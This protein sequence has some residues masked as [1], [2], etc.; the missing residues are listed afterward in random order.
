M[1]KV[2]GALLMLLACCPTLLSGQMGSTYLSTR[3]R[4]SPTGQ[5]AFH[6]V[7]STDGS[8]LYMTVRGHPANIGLANQDDIW[9][10]YL[11]DSSRWARPIHAGLPLNDERNN[12][13]MALG[14]DGNTIYVWIRDKDEAPTLG[15]AERQGRSWQQPEAMYIEGWDTLATAIQHWQVNRQEDVLL[16]AASLPGTE[17]NT[18]LFVSIRKNAAHWGQPQ[19]LEGYPNSSFQETSAYLAPDN[20]TLYFSSNRPGG[21]GGQDLYVCQRLDDSWSHWSSPVNLGA[22][23]NSELDEVGAC[24][25]ETGETLYF[26]VGDNSESSV[27]E[28]VLRPELQPERMLLCTGRVRYALSGEPVPAGLCLSVAEHGTARTQYCGIQ[29]DASGRFSLLVPQMQDVLVFAQKSSFFSTAQLLSAPGNPSDQKDQE[30]DFLGEIARREPTYRQREE[31]IQAVQSRLYSLSRSIAEMEALRRAALL[32]IAAL[33]DSFAGRT[34]ITWPKD[35]IP[36]HLRSS[37]DATREQYYQ[38]WSIP[39]PV[40]RGDVDP[41]DSFYLAEV[42]REKPFAQTAEGRIKE[43]HE[44]RKWK[45]EQEKQNPGA[46][47]P[48]SASLLNV[49]P[50][51]FEDFVADM[52]GYIAH[53]IQDSLINALEK[54]VFPQTIIA[55]RGSFA[56]TELADFQEV[57]QQIVREKQSAGRSG[58]SGTPDHLVYTPLRQP[59][60]EPFADTLQRCLAQ[61]VE[62]ALRTRLVNPVRAFLEYDILQRIYQKRME[63]QQSFLD[64]LI[65][66]QIQVEKNY[67]KRSLPLNPLSTT[68]EDTLV[69]RGNQHTQFDLWLYPAGKSLRFPLGN[70]SFQSNEAEMSEASLAELHR[71]AAF[72]LENPDVQ[73]QIDLYIQGP[74]SYVFAQE[75]TRDRAACIEGFLVYQEGVP[76]D[77]ISVRGRGK[78]APPSPDTE[79]QAGSQRIEV[80]LTHRKQ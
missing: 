16:L 75:L 11:S 24:T 14:L 79:T 57:I 5:T 67:R 27:Y 48:T 1:S 7:V 37:Y 58:L 44:R 50:S 28:A 63:A 68:R 41:G 10:A 80:T 23:I 43:L 62:S 71:L 31:D 56:E 33:P 49:T 47:P 53:T 34:A 46:I 8:A 52:Q 59:W 13:A 12:Q 51:S 61:S 6:P 19:R 30:V 4:I 25:S 17:G 73:A 54:E 2:Y 69:V 74:C 22:P 38:S 15:F 36:S 18:D 78:E 60:Q 21:M 66:K 45:N 76:A 35:I 72:L 40:D 77:R 29:T 39:E 32:R 70:V 65:Q 20:K 64:Q 3:Q 26:T 9:V 55:L 42:P